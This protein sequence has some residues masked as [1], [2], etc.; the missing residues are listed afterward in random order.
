MVRKGVM[1]RSENRLQHGLALFSDKANGSI[2]PAEGRVNG[3]ISDI[4]A[5]GP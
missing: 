2:K 4:P 5:G 3:K 1:E